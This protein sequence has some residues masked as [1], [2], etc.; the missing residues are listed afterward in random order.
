MP[1]NAG[2]QMAMPLEDANLVAS[3]VDE[4]LDR[5]PYEAVKGRKVLIQT[6][7]F[8][9]RQLMDMVVE[10]D[11]ILDPDYQRKYRWADEKASRFVE[12]IVLNIPVPVLYFAEEPDG[13][14]SVIDGQQRL[15]SLF[16][17]M[18]VSELANVFPDRGLDELVLNDA[19]KLRPDLAGV[20]FV[21]LSRD[22][23]STLAKRAIRCIVVLNES[24]P[25][26]KFEVFER[27]NSGSASLS[28][29]EVRNC[30]YRGSFNKLIK[31]LAENKKFQE[32]VA[33]PDHATKA[34]KDAELVLRFFAFR[35]ID[36]D[37][38]YQ[39]N[40]AEYLNSFMEENRELSSGRYAA[41]EKLFSETVD[42]LYETL[43]AG[44]AFRKPVDLNRPVDSGF[45]MN[46]ING[47][48][49]ES[50]MIVVSRLVEE[51]VGV[52]DLKARVLSVFAEPEYTGS[53][54]AGTSKKGRVL[55]RN[56]ALSVAVGLV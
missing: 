47:A 35:E 37:S 24:D 29:Q 45:A 23:R 1:E 11:L 19:M 15:T 10:G 9:V 36:E 50:Q 34:M 42:V 54:F 39:D 14:F 5:E 13:T 18:K 22:D 52:A 12:S 6:Y 28:D 7:D 55:R 33:L 26:L 3:G 41:L 25:T 53:I 20:R 4:D 51:G 56:K 2:K 27:L 48:V 31:S 49:Y 30:L 16:R 38:K 44:V 32:M 17:Y 21:D 46:L 8:A 43:G 40:Y